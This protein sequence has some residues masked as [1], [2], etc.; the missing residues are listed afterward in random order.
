MDI[1]LPNTAVLHTN[2]SGLWSTCSAAV[3]VTGLQ[4]CYVSEDRQ[5]G[6]LCVH[7]DTDD[8]DVLDHGLIYTDDLFLAEL[9]SLLNSLGLAGSA[10]SYSEAGMQGQDYV[11]L[12]AGAEFVESCAA[13]WP[14]ALDEL[15]DEI[16][17]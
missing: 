5:F 13:Q 9:A 4:L 2:G 10:V 15:Y 12:D 3:R 7:F 6:E 16:Y 17:G 1:S 11:S 14:A 8:W